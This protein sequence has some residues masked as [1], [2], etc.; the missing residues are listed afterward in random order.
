MASIGKS[1]M[2]PFLIQ[3]SAKHTASFIFLHGL[4]DN[5][6]GWCEGFN[7]I[8]IDYIKYI[9]P[10][11]PIRPV[12]IN[13][14]HKMP[15]WFDV[16][17]L[18]RSAPEDEVGVLESSDALREII[19]EEI[20]SGIDPTR[21]I[22]GGFSQG[23]AV[24]SYT[25]LTSNLKLGGL[26]LLSTYLPLAAKFPGALKLDNTTPLFQCHGDSDIVVGLKFG[27][28]SNEKLKTMLVNNQ[29]TI[30][31][32]LGHSTIQKEMEDVDKWIKETIPLTSI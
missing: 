30:Y 2:K 31:K 6:A 20:K 24:A 3:A 5:G 18:D 32:G 12:T 9:F 22:V 10:N 26:L 7:M 4:G 16:I 17:S 21:I 1:V 15:S 23:G 13:Q 14:N 8:K 25:A 19:N 27:Q 29:F 28:L 11:A